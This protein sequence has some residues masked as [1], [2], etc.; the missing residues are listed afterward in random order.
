MSS[1]KISLSSPVFKG[2]VRSYDTYRHQPSRSVRYQSIQ[3][4]KSGT[5][6]TGLKQ[7]TS[8]PD[9][10]HN[11]LKNENI[12]HHIYTSSK[13][14]N[15]NENYTKRIVLSSIR[16]AKIP[17]D[18]NGSLDSQFLDEQI[19]TYAETKRNAT[20]LQKVLYVFGALV[21]MFSALASIQ[22]IFTNKQAQDQIATLGVRT[23]EQGVSE[24]TGNEPSE[25]PVSSQAIA[26]YKVSNPND[27]RYLRIPSLGVFSRVKNLG[28]DSSGAVDAPWNINDA[29]WYNGSAR[30]GNSIGSSLILGHVSGWTAPG[31]F[32]NLKNLKTGTQ[33]EIE[34]GSGEVVTYEV[35][36]SESIPL[37]QINMSKILG[38][39]EPGKHDLKLMTCSGKYNSDTKTYEERY[40]VYAKPVI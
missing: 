36:R 8:E 16:Q 22:T 23:D 40:V 14:L 3:S 28:I 10:S 6:Q 37:D 13:P 20:K 27:P 26:A 33:F 38:A 39:E 12:Q 7:D 21:F 5:T 19:I 29:G 25:G 18:D 17:S 24:G 30:P 1:Q 11:N 4:R 35:T 31:V 34:K 9:I 32:K 15:S 2:R